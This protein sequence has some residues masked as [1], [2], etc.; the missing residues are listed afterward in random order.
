MRASYDKLT[1]DTFAESLMWIKQTY[2][3]QG[4]K[5]G[6]LLAWRI[7]KI[8]AERT[9]N[10]IKTNKEIFINCYA[11]LNVQKIEKLSIHFLTSCNF[12][13]YQRTRK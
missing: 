7:K 9:I 3:D 13:L 11:N 5:A 6:K 1:T 12:R 2:Y 10:S 4:E 8:Q